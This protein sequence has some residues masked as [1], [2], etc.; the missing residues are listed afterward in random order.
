LKIHFKGLDALRFYAALSV[1]IQHIRFS[2]SDWYGEPR[3]PD[4]IGRFFINGTDA[5]NLFF[6]LSGFLIT[7]LLLAERQNTGSVSVRGFYLRRILRIW[8]VYFLIIGLSA[9]V[10]P[11][12]VPGYHSP[13]AA[14]PA[15]AFL[16]LLF[17]GNFAFVVFF[18]YA[19]LE[20]IWSIAIEE[21][22]YLTIPHL[23]RRKLPL[24]KLLIG[25]LLGFWLAWII[26]NAP[27][28]PSAFASFLAM[29]RYDCI[30]IGGLFACALY[31]QWPVLRWIYHP[32]AGWLSLMV[33]ALAAMFVQP[34]VD[35]VYTTFTCFMFG[36]LILNVSTNERF[37]L[38]LD[39]RWLNYG[40]KISYGI[41]MYHPLLL[42][43]FHAW[44]YRRIDDDLYGFII[45]PL[46]IVTTL[47]VAVL[48][49]EG[50][51]RRLIALKDRFKPAPAVLPEVI[52]VSAQPDTSVELS[53]P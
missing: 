12:I 34:T 28:V 36:V 27:V 51:E 22:F 8:P 31:Y 19:P 21:Q 47:V 6:V 49:Y 26:V 35:L 18:P 29:M 14:N 48:S 43:V 46:V 16:L 7:Y 33:V 23:F 32:A 1:V 11:A 41:Y 37:F 5:V 20:H 39:Y 38:K 40:G 30:A 4:T 53:S 50:F 15:L 10:L 52:P 44:L 3:L 45:Y 13:L 17:M 25:F 2:P 24:P 42:L 9:F